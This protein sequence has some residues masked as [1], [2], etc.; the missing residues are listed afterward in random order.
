MHHICNPL[1]HLQHHQQHATPEAAAADTRNFP[2]GNLKGQPGTFQ[3]ARE[4]PGA[5]EAL[6]A[7]VRR[8]AQS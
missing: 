8:K 3:L 6:C 7:A 1:Q 5:F 4:D 2:V